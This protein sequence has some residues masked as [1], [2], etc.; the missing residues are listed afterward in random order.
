MPVTA[1]LGGID[2]GP[3]SFPLTPFTS[4]DQV[5]VDVLVAHL[6]TQIR[7]SPA[8][9]FA[10][11]GTGELPSLSHDEYRVVVNLAVETAAGR[12]P[13]FAGAGGGPATAR[14]HIRLAVECDA[15]GILLFPPY[16]ISARPE[17][18][19]EFV[20]YVVSGCPLPVVIYQ[21]ANVVLSE[22]VMDQLLEIE[23]VVGLKDG[24]GDIEL[25][26][27]IVAAIR[28]SSHPKADGF[29]F[30]DGL[31]TAEV[32]IEAYRAIGVQAYSS[33]VHSFFPEMAHAFFA[34]L[35]EPDRTR[36]DQLMRTFFIPFAAL[37]DQAPGYAVSLVKAGAFL[38]GLDMGQ[39][40]P[41]LPSVAEEH[42]SR[43]AALVESG[44]QA[45]V[46]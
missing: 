16:L 26:Q 39:A 44:R 1:S 7:A 21:R 6:E 17:D 42:K 35:E 30:F 8:A 18:A 13:V 40:R 38:N 10:A 27:R 46:L 45:L 24:V 25:I 12:L 43:L 9:L 3:I 31:P 2:K 33:A 20:R 22:R 15:D 34:A 5:A 37:R 29:L 32:T 36:R 11:C 14:E 28:G 23:P 4:D 19:V 41:P